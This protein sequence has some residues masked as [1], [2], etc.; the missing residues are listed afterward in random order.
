[1]RGYAILGVVLAHTGQWTQPASAWAVQFCANGALG[2]QLFFVASA[3]A[4]FLSNEHRQGRERR[5][6]GDF[7]IRRFCRIAPMFYVG[8]VFFVWLVGDRPRLWAPRGVTPS[9]IGLTALFLH[10]WHPE[11][12]NSVVP[13]GWSIAVE[14]SFYLLLPL[15]FRLAT[16][17]TRAFVFLLFTLLLGRV[18]DD[19][20]A[21]LLTPAYPPSYAYLA[22]NFRFFWIFS[23]LPVFALG[24]LLYYLLRDRRE[25]PD[26]RLGWL[27]LVAALGVFSSVFW[28][29]RPL[30]PP[31]LPAV[32]LV[33]VSCLLFGFA[34]HQTR[35]PLLVNAPAVFLGKISYSLY[36]VH[37]AVFQYLFLHWPAG[38]PV[39]G[40]WATPLAWVLVLATAGAISF[41]TYRWIELPGIALGRRLV[42]KIEAR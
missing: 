33:G 10:G 20:L 25:K 41:A 5:P 13:G 35:S 30:S 28:Q 15:L 2:V 9:D 11:T 8:L 39:S 23:Q 40:W 34:L 16:N 4:L 7:F 6:V 18:A 36:F 21:P 1:M 3:F 38:L 12:I 22:E 19:W 27:S 29:M 42:A 14:V 24:I 26:R 32:V 17:R 31:P 37:F